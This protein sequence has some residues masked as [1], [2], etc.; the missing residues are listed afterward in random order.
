MIEAISAATNEEQQRRS[1]ELRSS[2]VQPDL[3][4]AWC[5]AYTY[6]RHEF[7]V[8]D[9]VGRLGLPSFLPTYE[10]LRRWHDRRVKLTL[11][12]FPGYVFVG[13]VG[14]DRSRLLQLPGVIDL[15]RFGGRIASLREDEV[16]AI[17]RTLVTHKA[18]PCPFVVTGKRVRF[19]GGALDGLEGVVL[20]RK[21]T[22]RVVVSIDSIQ[23]SISIEA[24]V[25]DL[26]HVA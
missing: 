15:V 8:S 23:R 10:S 26:Q 17:R 7:R 19:R 11:P 2:A 9:Q 16:E 21:G 25:A 12:L 14:N 22:A 6:P 24:S 3:G 4:S 18:Q 20:R 5:V 13:C 1:I